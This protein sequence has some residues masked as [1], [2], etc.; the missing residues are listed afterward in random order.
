MKKIIISLLALSAVA[1]KKNPEK[2]VN[3]EVNAKGKTITDSSVISKAKITK[4]QSLKKINEDIIQALKDKNF[5]KFAEFIHPEKGVRFS[6]YAFVNPKEDKKFSK[7]DFIRYQP[8]KTLFTWGTMDGS[9]DLYRATIHDYLADWVYSKDFATAQV[10]L[11]EFQGKGNSLNNVKEIYPNADFTENFM[12]GSEANSGMDWKCLRLI[13][14]EFQ[15]TYYLIGVVNDQ[16][17]I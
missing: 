15:G 7:A 2:F 1:C 16:W 8:T 17:T 13:F 11:N 14:E 12:K 6:M 3:D 4:D 10:S 5:K 9:G